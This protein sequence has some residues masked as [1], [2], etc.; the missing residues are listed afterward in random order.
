[1][2][3]LFATVLGL[4]AHP[5]A[6][7]PVTAPGGGTHEVIGSI[8]TRYQAL[9]G[10]AGPLGRPLTDELRTPDESGRY[11]HFERG[12]I[13]WSPSAGAH[14]VMG[15][16]RNTWTYLGWERGPLGYPT[17]DERVSPGGRGRYNTFVG[18][19]I[20]WSPATGAREVRGGI[21]QTYAALGWD[22]S[23]LGFPVTNEQITPNGQGRY[24]VFQYGSI[25]WSPTT[26]A[27]AV[28]GAIRD[29]WAHEGW[30]AGWLGFP[31][32]EEFP[33][34]GGRAQDFQ[35]G[36]IGWTPGGGTVIARIWRSGCT[37][38]QWDSYGSG[39]GWGA[40]L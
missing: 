34:P 18:G 1:V 3:V 25:Y 16:I 9:G 22:R 15:A 37:R 40:D 33:V 10:P 26:G 5:A 35:C 4:G 36:S 30:E 38:F 20:L 21:A 8:L 6:A 27:H 11:N 32:T 19:A 31:I 28:M 7:D 13:Y 17:S 24:S 12:S 2:A 29:R 39:F 14:A 23:P